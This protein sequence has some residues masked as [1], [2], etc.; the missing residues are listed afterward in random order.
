M[1][2]LIEGVGR[3]IRKHLLEVDFHVNLFARVPKP[4]L[5]RFLLEFVLY[6]ISL[7]MIIVHSGDL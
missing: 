4:G 1:G 3:A 7:M 2:T 5:P 6:N